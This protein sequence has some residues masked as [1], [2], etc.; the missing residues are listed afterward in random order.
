M[1]FGP[2]PLD[3]ARGAIMAHTQRVRRADDPNKGSVLDEAAI[4]AL[5]EAGRDEVI[6][7]RLEP[8]D[9]PED[10]AADRL[11]QPLVSP[12]LART[13]AATGRVN[14]AAEVPGLL[15]VDAAMIDRA[16]RDRRVADHRHAAGLCGR[17]RRRTWWRP[18]RSF[19]SRC[20]ARCCGGRGAGRGRPGSPLTLHPFRPLKVGLV[21]T[22]LP[23][24][25]DSVTEKTDR[26]D[27]SAGRPG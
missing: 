12:L 19:R 25:K 13:R 16:E 23:G 4:A 6:V 20:P 24:L 18:S 2:V 21:V 27:R 3:E 1:K 14:L 10:I 15:R 11:A 17:W 26:G 5:R 8:G 7:A 9:V 22:E